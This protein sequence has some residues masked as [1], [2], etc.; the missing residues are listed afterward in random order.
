M[1]VGGVTW[2][3]QEKGGRGGAGQ[4]SASAD[5]WPR[6]PERGQRAEGLNDPIVWS[7]AERLVAWAQS[8]RDAHVIT[9]MPS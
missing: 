8:G 4:R 9:S 6:E 1:R 7:S 2:R 3:R 5:L